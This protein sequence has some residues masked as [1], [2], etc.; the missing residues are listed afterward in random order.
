MAGPGEFMATLDGMSRDRNARA[1]VEAQDSIKALY[2]QGF[3]RIQPG[4]IQAVPNKTYL[5]QMIHMFDGATLSSLQLQNRTAYKKMRFLVGRGIKEGSR[6]YRVKSFMTGDKVNDLVYQDK[7]MFKAYIVYQAIDS[8]LQ[9]EDRTNYYTSKGFRKYICGV[10]SKSKHSKSHHKNMRKGG[11]GW[12]QAW[13]NKR[14]G[15][16]TLKGARVPGPIGKK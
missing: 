7:D 9:A 11:K 14:H 3:K 5:R 16:V 4:C 10:L 1:W 2:E 15:G 13:K 6:V 12:R 8:V